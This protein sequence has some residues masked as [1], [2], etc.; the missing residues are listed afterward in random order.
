MDGLTEWLLGGPPWARY[1][2]LLD[3]L[4]EPE[5]APQVMT[6]RQALMADRQVKAL[7]ADLDTWPGPPLKRHNDAGHLLHKL[8]FIADLVLKADDACL[9]RVVESILSQ[10]S[11]EGLFRVVF[12]I[13]PRYGGTGEDQWAWMLCDAPLVL[14][15]VLKLGLKEDP[16]V[17]AAAH[18]LTSLVREN[19]WPCAVAPELGKFRGPGRKSD[20]C[21]Y[22]TL[23]ML[24]ALSEVP[25]WRDSDASRI[26]AETLL[27]LWEQR[28]ERRPY[29]FAMGTDFGKLKA[30]LIWYDILHVTDVLTRLPWLHEDRRLRE[31]V[32][33]VKVKADKQGCFTS[34]SVWRAWG[35]WEFDQK[36]S[37]SRW[38]TLLSRRML[39][40]VYG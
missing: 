24:K 11:S 3:L 17:Q 20:P 27:G 39:R 9:D 38:L 40:R 6:A 34:E 28:K 12:N 22:A 14:Y 26:G 13:A 37:P 2:T 31:M 23:L 29:L 18:H 21:P 33:T 8:V 7:L 5:D 19:G 16:R 15:A 32:E 25:E 36:R 10:R 1:R 30:P 35:E 4:D